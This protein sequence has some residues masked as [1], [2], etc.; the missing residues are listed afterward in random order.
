[1]GPMVATQDLSSASDL[2]DGIAGVSNPRQL[3]EVLRTTLEEATKLRSSCGFLLVVIDDLRRVNET[4]GSD[5]GETVV[6]AVAKRLRTQLRGKDHLGRYSGDTFG[7][8]IN[9]CTPDAMQ[10]AADRLLAGV[11][12]E[13]VQTEA[14]ALAVTV[15]IGGVIAPRHGRMVREV[16]A[17]AEETLDCTKV[18]RGSFQAYPPNGETRKLARAS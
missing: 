11:R 17:R 7:V 10:V 15:T 8:V 12:D 6:A 16:L 1:M 3:T 13:P 14:G 4:Y 9:N 2:S 5:T 18:R